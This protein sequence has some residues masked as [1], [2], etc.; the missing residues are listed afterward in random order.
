M[1]EL[2]LQRAR[3]VA[4]QRQASLS[5]QNQGQRPLPDG[6]EMVA[7]FEDNGRIYRKPDGTLEA[8]SAGMSTSD[9]EAI[10][11]L[12]AGVPL[13]DV[14]QGS[15]DRDIIN[16]ANGVHGLVK[17]VEG[18]PFVGS[19]I[20]EAAGFIAGDDAREGVRAVSAAMGRERP[21]TSL[22]A[23]AAGTVASIPA[24]LAAAPAAGASTLGGS[25]LRLAGA[26]AVEGAVY[27]AG[28][29]EG[30]ASRGAES[31]K[32]AAIGGALGGALGLAAPVIKNVGQNAL[33]AVRGTAGRKTAGQLGVSQE[34]AGEIENALRVGSVSDAQ[35]SLARAGGDAMLADAG[36]AGRNLLD[37]S[38]Q[39]GGQAGQIVADAVGQRTTSATNRMVGVLD[40]VLG[41]AA[42]ERELIDAARQSTA[43]QRSNAYDAAYAQPIDYSAGAGRTLE[44]LMR[45]VP[46]SAIRDADALM[47]VNGE[48]SA[49]IMA[50][51]D[52]ESVTFEVMPD[53]RQMHYIMQALRGVAQ[54]TNTAGAMGGQTP[55]GS[56]YDR[57]AGQIG[58]SLKRAV[59]EFGTA[60]DAA[61]DTIQRVQATEL[62]YNLLGNTVR[63]EDVAR[64]MAGASNA[65]KQSVRLGIRSY[66]DE[67][68]SR[69]ARTNSD[70][71]T[72]AREGIKILRDFSTRG[73]RT[74]LNMV[75][76][77]SNADRLLSEIDQA[78]TAF[79]L[80][81]AVSTNSRTAGRQAVQQGVSERASQGVLRSLSSGEPV[82]A[83]KR[84]VQ[85]IT[86]ETP[87]ARQL[88]ELGIYEEIAQTL[89]QTRGP[90]ASRALS[91]INN[92]MEGRAVS[93]AQA[94][95][96]ARA[97]LSASVPQ[98]N[99]NS[100]PQI[101]QF[102]DLPAP[103]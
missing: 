73:N 98:A 20:D 7:T 89:T 24:M 61:A 58:S 51:I 16:Q 4:R 36:V 99:R 1:S 83:T 9:Q 70:D 75:L 90:Q 18:V 96:I 8:A 88:R 60:Q 72:V 19:Y 57:L 52:G 41:G 29:G 102:L 100:T 69:V 33:D 86:G 94:R 12:M 39:A 65:E 28:R 55:L 62:G 63:R 68:T 97:V 49:Q 53:V 66:V 10:S 80:R 6:Y 54:K 3:A 59:P 34:A 82:N 81:A 40:D 71:D 31:V 2:E 25:V 47:R 32:G 45:R 64:A 21:K 15:W 50:R 103:R 101:E 93:E 38:A 84:I 48:E 79:E 91:I 92:A 35:E 11:G 67:V 78:A 5:T 27:G 76:G 85:V 87:E 26:G 43:G 14:M 56:S 95:L 42:G 13:A 46:A 44:T 37:A 77:P 22:G 17:G 74:K 23:S 30:A